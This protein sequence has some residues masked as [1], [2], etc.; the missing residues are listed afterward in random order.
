MDT[1]PGCKHQRSLVTSI[2][3]PKTPLRHSDIDFHDVFG[4]PPQQFSNQVTRCN[5]EEGTKPS[6]LREDEDGASVCYPWTDLSEKLVLREASMVRVSSNLISSNG[7]V[8]PFFSFSMVRLHLSV[9]SQLCNYTSL[10]LL[11][12]ATAPFSILS[13]VQLYLSFPSQ[14][15]GCTFLYSLNGAVAP[16]FHFSMVQL[17]LSLPSQWGGYKSCIHLLKENPTFQTTPPFFS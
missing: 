2:S 17:H 5:F 4:S 8:A 15:C 16:L 14:W 9:F 10:S 11:N 1:I 3:L 12:G 6:A 13:I 7:V